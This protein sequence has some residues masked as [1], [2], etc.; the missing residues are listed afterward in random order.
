MKGLLHSKKFRKN[1][2]KWLCMYV[3]VL[4]LFTSVVTYSKYVSS[5]SGTSEARVAKFKLEVVPEGCDIAEDTD[6]SCVIDEWRP[7]EAKTFVVNINASFEVLT[8]L[9]LSYTVNYNDGFRVSEIVDGLGNEIEFRKSQPTE[10]L[11]FSIESRKLMGEEFNK[12]LKITVVYDPCFWKSKNGE[13][14][15]PT[16]Y[17]SIQNKKVYD[18]ISVGYLANQ[19]LK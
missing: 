3:G 6:K 14:C 1:L 18:I 12:V 15:D 11:D 4:M 17:Q 2:Y 7:T 19:M 9:S 16:D 10:Y 5:I 13:A 8:N